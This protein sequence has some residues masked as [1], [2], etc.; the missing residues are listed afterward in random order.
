MNSFTTKLLPYLLL[1]CDKRFIS[2]FALP[3]GTQQVLLVLFLQP[4]IVPKLCISLITSSR[5]VPVASRNMSVISIVSKETKQ[6]CNSVYINSTN[7]PIG[8]QLNRENLRNKEEKNR[9]KWATLVK[10]PAQH[11]LATEVTV[12]I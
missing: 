2:L 6:D 8:N 12:D 4:E 11:H 9:R 3:S 10:T 1:I 5:Q 7:F